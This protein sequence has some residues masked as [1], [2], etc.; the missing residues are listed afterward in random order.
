MINGISSKLFVTSDMIR[1]DTVKSDMSKLYDAYSE[2]YGGSHS[3]APAPSVYSATIPS[4]SSWEEMM[5]L[6]VIDFGSSSSSYTRS[7]L[8]NYYEIN[9]SACFAIRLDGRHDF[10]NFDI[11]ESPINCISYSF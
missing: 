5:N 7:E 3:S 11:L 10:T 2:R 8:E 9:F 1:I 4:G 6:H